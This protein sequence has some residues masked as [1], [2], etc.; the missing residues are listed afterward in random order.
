[1]AKDPDDWPERC[2]IPTLIEAESRIDWVRGCL[3]AE[4]RQGKAAE[5]LG[6][7]VAELKSIR[8]DLLNQA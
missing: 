8:D 7:I 2:G 4:G 3:G 6:K 5:R 1:M